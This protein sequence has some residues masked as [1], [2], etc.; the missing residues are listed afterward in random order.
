MYLKKYLEKNYI[1][2][3]LYIFLVILGIV[4]SIMTFSK[5]SVEEKTTISNLYKNSKLIQNDK[6]EFNVIASKILNENIKNSIIIVLMGLFVFG[7]YT[8]MFNGFIIGFKIGINS[9]LLYS[10]LK[11][12][13]WKKIIIPYMIVNILY[14][15][16]YTIISIFNYKFANELSRLIEEENKRENIIRFTFYNIVIFIIVLIPIIVESKIIENIINNFNN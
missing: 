13:L 6:A 9:S 11:E 14:I 5:I 8:I 4:F 7:K 10:L 16:F 3:Y 12:E 2:V 15:S 1:P